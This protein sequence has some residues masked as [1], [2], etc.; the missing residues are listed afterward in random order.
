MGWSEADTKGYLGEPDYIGPRGEECYGSERTYLGTVG[1]EHLRALNPGAVHV[2]RQV[3]F[4]LVGHF[5]KLPGHPWLTLVRSDSVDSGELIHVRAHGEVQDAEIVKPYAQWN[6]LALTQTR[7]VD[8][9]PAVL[10]P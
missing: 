3:V 10:S 2:Y 7:R 8:D 6:D 1:I 5:V 4:D 9:G